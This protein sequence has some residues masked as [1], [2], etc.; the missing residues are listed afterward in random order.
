M[1]LS[2]ILLWHKSAGVYNF[3]KVLGYGD[4]KT[5]SSTF[6]PAL[7]DCLLLWV[8]ILFMLCLIPCIMSSVDGGMKS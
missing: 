8:L 7:E 5:V 3:L 2:N 6:P 1:F 4:I